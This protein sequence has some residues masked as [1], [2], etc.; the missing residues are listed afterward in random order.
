MLRRVYEIL[1]QDTGKVLVDNLTFDEATEQCKVYQDFFD[2]G[3]AV[4]IRESMVH[5]KHT[6][7]K[8]E[9]KEAWISYFAE[10]QVMG[11]LH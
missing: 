10:L 6:T 4:V 3:V 9:F 1:D 11:N 7:I 8:Q 2:C 5:K